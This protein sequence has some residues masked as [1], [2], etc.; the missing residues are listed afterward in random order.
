MASEQSCSELLDFLSDYVDGELDPRLCEQIEQHMDGC[1]TA[2]RLSERSKAR[3]LSIIHCRNI[4][5]PP[6]PPTDSAQRWD[7]RMKSLNRYAG[8]SHLIVITFLT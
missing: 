2:K 3:S 4:N 8:P 5:S 7:W 6:A 1:T